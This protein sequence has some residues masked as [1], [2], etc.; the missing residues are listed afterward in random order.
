MIEKD[1][2]SSP[3]CAWV[4]TLETNPKKWYNIY[5]IGEARQSPSEGDAQLRFVGGK[6]LPP[7]SPTARS[8]VARGT[9]VD[10]HPGAPGR[11]LPGGRQD[12]R[13]RGIIQHIYRGNR[14]PV[15]ASA[16]KGYWGRLKSPT[17]V[18]LLIENRLLAY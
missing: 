17:F 7:K 8:P 2:P 18:I 13:A 16:A 1:A 15:E 5:A 3:A 9:N 11:I 6:T 4:K 12:G 10:Q 14:Y